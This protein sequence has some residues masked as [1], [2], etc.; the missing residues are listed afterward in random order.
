MRIWRLGS[1]YVPS[2]GSVVVGGIT[3]VC[4]FEWYAAAQMHIWRLGSGYEPSCGSVGVR[5]ITNQELL[6]TT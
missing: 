1:G 5:G 2:C 4:N 3:N 6:P